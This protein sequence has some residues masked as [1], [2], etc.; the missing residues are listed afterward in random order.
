GKVR[1]PQTCNA[2]SSDNL[3]QQLYPMVSWGKKYLTA[4]SDN[5]PNN[6]Y[7][8]AKSNPAANVYVNGVLVPASSF[9]NG[10]WYQ[11]FNRIPN[12]IESDLPISVTQYFTTQACDGNT[13]NL[14]DPDMIVLN[15]VEQNINRVTLV[16]PPL[17]NPI[18]PYEHHLQIVMPTAG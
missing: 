14:Y 11:F 3:Y 17:A 9:T 2:T 10:T 16:N 7:R 4:P 15:P 12:L 1:I 8:I 13:G 6:Y 18:P 5:N